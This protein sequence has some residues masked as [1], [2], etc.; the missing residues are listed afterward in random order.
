MLVVL[1]PISAALVF[2]IA[3][4]VMSMAPPRS[5][6][7]R[8][9]ALWLAVW[10]E[11]VL[12]V[13]ILSLIDAITPLGFLIC[14]IV[15][16]GIAV[17]VW[18]ARGMPR[19]RLMGLLSEGEDDRPGGKRRRKS[20]ARRKRRRKK[21]FWTLV[22]QAVGEHPALG[23]L[24][25]VVAICAL[26]N[27]ALAVALPVNNHDAN[28]YHLSRVGYW[29]QHGTTDHYFTHNA[30]QNHM[31]PNAEFGILSMM[32]F[33]R[34]EWPAPLG[35]YAAYFI[36]L[37]AVYFIARELGVSN[38]AALF[39]ALVLG[40]MTEVILQS[41]IPK[42]G[43]VVSS[44]LVC[45]VAFALVGL[46]PGDA[47]RADRLRA[48]VWSGVAT[49]L[50]VGTKLTALLFLP[51]LAI[52]GGVVAAGG[53]RRSTWLGRLAAWAGCCVV[54]IVLLGS[55]NFI[56]IFT[57]GP[58]PRSSTPPRLGT[59]AQRTRPLARSVATNLARFGT[60]ARITRPT[61]RSV[62]SNLARYGYHLCDFGGV[63]PRSLAYGA[64]RAR[65]RLGPRVFEALG[66][67]ANAPELNIPGEV[68]AFPVDNETGWF[69]DVPRLHED[70]AW[71]GPIACFVGLPLVLAHLV[72]SPVRRRWAWFGVVLV[73]VVY[74]LVV[75]VVLRYSVWNGRYFVTTVV[76]AAPLLAFTYMPGSL[77]P[78]R[79][80]LT[81]LL[82]VVGASTALTATFYNTAKPIVPKPPADDQVLSMT[83]TKGVLTMPR[84]AIRC[85]YNAPMGLSLCRLP[86]EAFPARMTLGLVLGGDD[87][88][89][90]LFGPGL[91][92]KLVPLPRNSAR[93]AEAFRTGQVDMVLIRK[94]YG[95]DR[96]PPILGERLLLLPMETTLDVARVNSWSALFHREED[97]DLLFPTRDWLLHPD[98]YWV[99]ADQ[100]FVPARVLPKGRIVVAIKPNPKVVADTGLVFEFYG[101]ETKL[102]ELEV[103]EMREYYLAIDWDRGPAAADQIL[104]IRVRAQRA[105]FDA[106]LQRATD[107]YLLLGMPVFVSAP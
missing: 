60:D 6:V 31:P 85:R 20:K 54:G 42:N 75:C 57:R 83:T 55:F 13:E 9:L 40:T 4:I 29:I 39:A 63:L 22:F 74:W 91:R 11:V 59:E 87:C 81:W 30:R 19:V 68:G 1:L 98:G 86:E 38:A 94:T 96:M 97:E 71:F 62:A 76:A 5:R 104:R 44:F 18:L 56:R 65:A 24:L 84:V 27:L 93:V 17:A 103:I 95:L 48:L 14:Y 51:A 73:P 25:V 37:A 21:G 80:G 105:E 23:V 72:W 89:W 46:G 99:D 41:T 35:Q 77:G 102:G 33:A 36:C 47:S 78:A 64:T 32:I 70:C 49:G 3:Y 52:A 92:R 88:D 100:R 79:F 12:A 82:V 66:I 2:G 69:D 8:W 45:A 10:A 101:G 34:A 61:V 28:S 106:N 15:F 53:G 58:R 43:L 50:A 90:P 7:G 26:V 67:V 16:A 107:I